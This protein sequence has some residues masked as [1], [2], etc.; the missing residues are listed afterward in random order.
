MLD[1]KDCFLVLF[2]FFCELDTNLDMHGEKESQ[3]KTH[4]PR[5]DLWAWLRDIFLIAS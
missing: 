5:N 4:L 3:L 2:L 1:V